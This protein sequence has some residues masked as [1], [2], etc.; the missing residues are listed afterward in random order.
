MP[1]F[2]I[3]TQADR[4]REAASL[5]TRE[6]GSIL[7]YIAPSPLAPGWSVF[8]T[9][10]RTIRVDALKW[11]RSLITYDDMCRDP[12]IQGLLMSVAL[13]IRH[14]QHYV[15]PKGTTGTV[16][17]EIAEDFGLPLLGDDAAD[18]DGDGVDY[19][20]HLRLALLALAY[21]H[22]AFEESGAIQGN[23]PGAK[24]RLRG[25]CERPNET[26]QRIDVTAG[27]DLLSIRVPSAEPDVDGPFVDVPDDHLLYYCWDRR[28]ADWTGRPLLYG[29]Y[30]AWLLKD[31]LI[32]EDATMTRRFGGIP[33]V[34]TTDPNVGGTALTD[35]ALMAQSVQSGDGAGVALP[36]GTRLRILGVEGTLPKP[37]ESVKYHDA[38]MARAFMQMVMELGNSAH[39]SRAL[40]NTLMD[41][42]ALGVLSIAKWIRKSQMRLVRRIV[43][44]NYGP[45][46]PVPHIRS[47]QDDHE[48]IATAD[49]VSLIESGAIVVDDD[50]EAQIRERGNLVPRNPGQTGRAPASTPTAPSSTSSTDGG[51]TAATRKPADFATAY[52]DLRDRYARGEIELDAF[53]R[54][55]STLLRADA[56]EP[57]R[58]DHGKRSHT[59]TAAEAAGTTPPAGATTDFAALQSAFEDALAALTAVWNVVKAGQ[60]DD[61]VAQIQAATS[62]AEVAAITPTVTG[63]P[64]LAAVLTS[65]VEHGAQTVV[66]EAAA[67]GVTLALPDLTETQGQITEAADG[68]AVLLA[69]S[70]GAS[71]ASKAISLWT[72]ATDATSVA[73][74]VQEHLQ[75][76]VGVAAD[77]ELAG[78]ASQAQNSGRF[79]ALDS[80]D[81]Q[82]GIYSSEL[83]D[84]PNC[85]EPCREVNDTNYGSMA[86]ARRDYPVAG[87]VGCAGLK[88]CRGTLVKIYD[89][90]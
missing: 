73:V 14:M 54:Q 63:G 77:Y 16:A 21:G 38:Q 59:A 69:R 10:A 84:D 44:R 33:V 27:G 64:E 74:A 29:L 75:S 58:H 36:Y 49:L 67:Q 90:A 19:D 47:R 65:V 48:D 23:G 34:E 3:L 30:R 66:D 12:Q 61:L 41:H 87:Y 83:N 35:A 55:V 11:P 88:R 80:D 22:K 25:L 62:I 57:T 60:I 56:G 82:G 9:Q 70:L 28:G 6:R 46:T 37:L 85:C 13:P 4:V 1:E 31:E 17:E 42:Y 50:L 26:I 68:V 89:E 2:S 86:E 43:T 7:P 18:E 51:A 20:E 72:G 8:E 15:D 79:A 40:G 52:E 76:L 78:L 45:D 24:Y 5:P 53:E 39:G 71:A 32:R 81:T